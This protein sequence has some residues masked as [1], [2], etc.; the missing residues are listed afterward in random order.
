MASAKAPWYDGAYE[1][2]AGRIEKN[3]GTE[4]PYPGRADG[5]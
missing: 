3:T 4:E 2:Q 5:G 1:N